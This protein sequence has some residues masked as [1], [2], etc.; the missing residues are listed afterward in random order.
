VVVV[1]ALNNNEP[2]SC[3]MPS[4]KVDFKGPIA[5]MHADAE[6]KIEGVGT[7]IFSKG[8]VEWKPHKNSKNL[9]RYTWAQF[10]KL[11]ADGGAPARKEGGQI[12]RVAKKQPAINALTT[13]NPQ[14]KWPYP[15]ATKARK[16][17]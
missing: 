13:L 9:R 10:G 5:V 11:L 15:A 2:E 6:M 4:V 12:T 7:L 14:A 3:F 1:S 8:S 16:R 17:A